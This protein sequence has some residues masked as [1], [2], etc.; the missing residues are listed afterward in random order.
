MDVCSCLHRMLG[1][2]RISCTWDSAITQTEKAGDRKRLLTKWRL[3]TLKGN[4]RYPTQAC[5]WCTL[6]HRVQPDMKPTMTHNLLI[7]NMTHIPQIHVHNIHNIQGHAFHKYIHT[8]YITGHIQ[9]STKHIQNGTHRNCTDTKQTDTDT[10]QT[11]TY[12]FLA[13]RRLEAGGVEA[14]AVRLRDTRVERGADCNKN[15]RPKG[16]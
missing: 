1:C 8:L 16:N 3:Y 11:D 6:T 9:N 10:K 12:Y 4:S 15:L 13:L 14:D 5:T 2:Q 7:H